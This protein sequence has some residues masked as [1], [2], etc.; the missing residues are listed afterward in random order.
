M[1]GSIMRD[2]NQQ[3]L[4]EARHLEKASFKGSGSGVPQFP[5]G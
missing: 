1:D 5:L 4:P 2:W 3:L